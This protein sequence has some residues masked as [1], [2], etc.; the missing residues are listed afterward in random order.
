M[1]NDSKRTN[2]LVLLM[3]FNQILMSFLLI[4]FN[5]PSYVENNILQMLIEVLFF[6]LP[7]FIYLVVTKK[8]I[9]KTI[10][11]NPIS[12]KECF[13]VFVATVLVKPILSFF[14]LLASAF[15]PNAASEVII[16][17]L[18]GSAIL[19]FLSIAIFPPICEEFFFRG[20]VFTGFKKQPI[21][22]ACILSGLFFGIAHMN[23]NQLMYTLVGGIFF[24]YL[25]YLT[26]SILAPIFAHFIIN[27]SQ[28]I[29][30]YSAIKVLEATGQL[31]ELVGT[32]EINSE[33]FAAVL[34][35]GIISLVCFLVLLKLLKRLKEINY[36]KIDK[37]EFNPTEEEKESEFNVSFF[38][39]IFIY[40]INIL[41][42][43]KL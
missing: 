9:R 33:F 25:M 20:V 28:F 38:I 29:Q 16:E 2:N 27:G 26:N 31:E 19:A 17:S 39:V 3:L 8:N 1:I 5:I 4:V 11:L 24:S 34:I 13:Y 15:F 6:V 37:T 42:M 43:S 41:A 18:N 22:K 7:G 32:M 14:A 10:K 12:G 23:G 36:D 30:S 21:L 40:L 35:Y